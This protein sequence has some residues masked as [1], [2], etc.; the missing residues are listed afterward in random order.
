M[1]AA[2]QFNFIQF[3]F[4]NW[5]SRFLKGYS[6][7]IRIFPRRKGRLE[8]HCA[9]VLTCVL[10]ICAGDLFYKFILK[11]V[12]ASDIILRISHKNAVADV[13][14][15]LPRAE[16][17]GFCY[18]VPFHGRLSKYLRANAKNQIKNIVL[19]TGSQSIKPS[20][21]YYCS[22]LSSNYR[23]NFIFDIWLSY[24]IGDILLCYIKLSTYVMPFYDR[25]PPIKL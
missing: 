9:G 12:R 23:T 18:N 10:R 19:S 24:T 6:I 16:N 22:V 20:L 8:Q 2:K 21:C 11:C 17:E 7:Q 4:R 1:P 14:L 25:H 15:P 3:V 5:K 13:Q